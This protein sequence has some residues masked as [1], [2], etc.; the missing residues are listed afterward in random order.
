MLNYGTMPLR[1]EDSV[2]GRDRIATAEKS[3]L[4]VLKF[5]GELTAREQTGALT[6]APNP[7]G[8]PRPPALPP[9]AA[10]TDPKPSFSQGTT[11]PC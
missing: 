9:A 4:R 3:L 5:Q 6:Y 10:K 11:R 8:L 1:L 2:Y 7:A